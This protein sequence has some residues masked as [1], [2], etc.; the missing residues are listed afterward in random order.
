MTSSGLRLLLVSIGLLAAACSQPPGRDN[1]VGRSSLQL[2]DENRPSWSG[3]GGRPLQTTV[4][5][6]ASE[7][8]REAEWRIGVFR[9]GWTAPDAR[10]A[11]APEKLPLVVLSHG[12]GGAAPQLSWLA[13][14][15]AANGYLVAAVNHHGNT[16]AEASY[17]PQGFALWWERAKD[18]SVLIDKLLAD[19]RFGPRIDASRI[20]VAG[21]SLGG[22]AALTVAGARTDRGQ[23]QR[24]CAEAAADPGCSLP[25]ES[26]FSMAELEDL[27][28][29]DASA[30][31][32][33][34]RSQKSH[35]DERVRAAFAIAPVLGPAID[36][37]SL[38]EIPIAVRIVVGEEDDQAVPETNAIPVQAAIPDAELRLLP[39]VGHY[40]F[41]APCTLRGRLLVRQLCEDPSGVERSELHAA[42][43]ADAVTYFDRALSNQAG[44][45]K[46]AGQ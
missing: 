42:I 36:R 41:L 34:E 28:A 25:P 13:E 38:Q 5:Y 43:G 21:F 8:S 17:L 1:P 39:G 10:L 29:R 22:Y 4:W 2:E 23:W 37:Q 3:T 11:S 19:S 30:K 16:A 24:Y 14:H 35:R 27:L 31:I 7:G 15:L 45:R 9:A 44:T 18:L 6:P 26:P 20:G 33:L 46:D 32:S 40:A 12:T